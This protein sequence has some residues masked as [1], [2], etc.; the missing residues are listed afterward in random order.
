MRL[1]IRL[2]WCLTL[3]SLAALLILTWG[4]KYSLKKRKGNRKRGILKWWGET[5]DTHYLQ[6]ILPTVRGPFLHS[7]A[8]LT[9]FLEKSALFSWKYVLCKYILWKHCVKL[10]SSK[11]FG[12]YPWCLMSSYWWL[13]ILSKSCLLF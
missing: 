10:P 7:M 9:K 13:V 6:S 3:R 11:Y 8:R 12:L 5:T 4:L 2:W 1:I